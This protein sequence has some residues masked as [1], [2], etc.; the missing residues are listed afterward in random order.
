[1][2]SIVDPLHMEP[3]GKSHGLLGLRISEAEYAA[4]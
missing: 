2:V 4:R 3:G 1:M